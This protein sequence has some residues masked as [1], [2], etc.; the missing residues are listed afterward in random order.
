MEHDCKPLDVTLSKK[1]GPRMNVHL[2]SHLAVTSLSYE[3]TDATPW[4]F[5]PPSKRS[6]WS[7]RYQRGWN[8]PHPSIIFAAATSYLHH[9]WWEKNLQNCHAAGCL[10][11]PTP[12]CD[13][14]DKETS[15]EDSAEYGDL[16]FSVHLNCGKYFL[17][18]DMDLMLWY[19]AL[20]RQLQQE[21]GVVR[22]AVYQMC[23]SFPQISLSNYVHF[24]PDMGL[25]SNNDFEDKLALLLKHFLLSNK[26]TLSIQLVVSLK[27]SSA[28]HETRQIITNMKKQFSLAAYITNSAL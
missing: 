18:Y 3:G 26:T 8:V 4:R 27:A 22:I 10:Q 7:L 20:R 15:A 2:T 9:I 11:V 5:F 23:I 24:L 1:W 13:G 19:Y 25:I 16:W 21:Q 28:S 17:L 12:R 14:I 6:S